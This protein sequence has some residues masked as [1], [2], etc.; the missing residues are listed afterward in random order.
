MRVV[1]GERASEM[2]DDNSDAWYIFQK[3]KNV[4]WNVYKY[5]K[6]I[7]GDGACGHEAAKTERFR[8]I[9]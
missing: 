2:F 3:K 8:V 5:N 4:T 1:V 6:Y 7:R 9:I